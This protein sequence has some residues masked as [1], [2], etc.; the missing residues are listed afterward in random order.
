[1]THW[2]RLA[3]CVLTAACGSAPA[4]GV[5]T[6]PVGGEA[7][8][9]IPAV[10]G[11]PHVLLRIGCD[12]TVLPGRAA[13]SRDGDEVILD[14][15]DP[16]EGPVGAE[17]V[18]AWPPLTEPPWL[19]HRVEAITVLSGG[20]VAV[21]FGGPP[22]GRGTEPERLFADHRLSGV[23]FAPREGD[24][25]D[26]IDAGQRVL[27]RHDASVG[28]ARSLG[29]EVRMVAFDQLYLVVFAGDAGD[30]EAAELGR[31][32]AADWAPWGAEGARRAAAV[33]WTG[34]SGRCGAFSRTAAARS[35]GARPAPE[36]PTVTYREGDL[37]GLQ[38]A[39]RIVSSAIRA[40]R[41]GST[42]RGLTGS[43]SRLSVR[44]VEGPRTDRA[45]S[46]VAAVFR[47]QAGP[48]HPCSLHAEVLRRLEEWGP[49][50]T[51]PRAN[52]M[53]IGEVAVFDISQAAPPVPREG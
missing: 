23:P 38:L 50:R 2:M 32:I 51:A 13:W 30:E 35:T 29:R 7:C 1:M 34:L 9:D 45:E 28:Y 37:P 4:E 18:E 42:V 46:D 43:V 53:L 33:T 20:R 31:A 10:V 24:A 26:A 8:A 25:R 6:A 3:C 36:N 21:R 14:F 27:T 15:P 49:L 40:D 48:G 47:V 16:G 17:L 12:G 19:G 22:G 39:E 5:A 52:V 41:P 44:A 11:Y